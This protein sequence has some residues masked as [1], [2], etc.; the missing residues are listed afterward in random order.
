MIFDTNGLS[1]LAD[2]ASGLERVLRQAHQIAIPVV[3]LGGYYYVILQS[4]DERLLTALLG[5]A[6]IS[7]QHIENRK[8][9]VEPHIRIIVMAHVV[10]PR[11]P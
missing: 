9:Y 4:H 6:A 5:Q 10:S 11:K 7:K 1:A 8:K 3:V 2:G